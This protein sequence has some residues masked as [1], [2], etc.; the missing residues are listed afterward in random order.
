MSPT[1]ESSRCSAKFEEETRISNNI[2][3]ELLTWWS[4][5]T[6]ECQRA[7]RVEQLKNR[8]RHERVL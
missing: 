4:W 3:E 6:K 8:M 1:E 2:L 7:G 5:A